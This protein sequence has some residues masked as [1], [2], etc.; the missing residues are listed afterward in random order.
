[1]F[2]VVA[3]V[4]EEVLILLQQRLITPV[5]QNGQLFSQPDQRLI[6]GENRVIPSNLILGV[7]LAVIRV[8]REPGFARRKA[9]VG[10]RAPL[11]GRPGVVAAFPPDRVTDPS[12]GVTLCPAL[13]HHV[14]N[15]DIPAFL[16]PEV[17]IGHAELFALIDIG[18]PLHPVQED[19][20]HLR[21]F[22]PV[23]AVVG[24]AGDAAR[25]IVILPEKAVPALTVK[26]LL[27]AGEDLFQFYEVNRDHVP[28]L[29]ARDLV[30]LHVLKLEDHGKLGSVRIAVELCP[31]Y[32]RAPGFSDRH[33][34]G[35]LK[36]RPAHLADIGMQRGGALH[37]AVVRVFSQVI[38]DIQAE[39]A[40]ATV[41]PPVDHAVELGSE[42]RIIPVQ[43][44]LF[45]RKLM[46]IIL[47]QFRHPFPGRAAETGL[48]LIRGRHA[49]AVAPDV[50]VVIRILPALFCLDEPA[51]LIRGMVQHQIQ[52]DP[53]PALPCLGNQVVHVLQRSEDGIDVLIVRDV[54]SIVI[55]RR[56]EDRREPDCA[57][58]KFLKII[59]LCE[60]P[61][62]VPDSVAVGVTEAP[63]IDLVNHRLLP[64]GDVH[65]FHSF[66]PPS[67]F[68]SSSCVNIFRISRIQT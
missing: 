62:E 52:N 54:I 39:A 40:D 61:G 29:F 57:D 12:F 65:L 64:P 11:H 67:F 18:R 49:V 6:T 2:S 60:D 9:G 68:S 31:L 1:M 51:V 14:Q 19:C 17:I 36:G 7:D 56:A 41:G 15:L 25:Q 16:Y 26:A 38:H 55:L 35:S 66:F 37:K 44:R 8:H 53:D 10:R 20:Q 23:R 43:I 58:A 21:R 50:V 34:A 46:E 22:H 59:Q 3:A 63:R 42:L 32:I 4:R 13:A 48:Q 33:Q 45:D 5:H 28:F 47:P 27:P 24:E 30:D